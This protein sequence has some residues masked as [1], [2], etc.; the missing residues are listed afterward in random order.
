MASGSLR[1]GLIQTPQTPSEEREW[2]SHQRHIEFGQS[3]LI[4]VLFGTSICLSLIY[5][6]FYS[7][8]SSFTCFVCNS[9]SL[10]P[11]SRHKQDG[12][13]TG[14]KLT[15]RSTKPSIANKVCKS[16]LCFECGRRLVQFGIEDEDGTTLRKEVTGYFDSSGPEMLF[17]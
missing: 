6:S 1:R 11:F 3:R 8:T 17:I 7:L 15:D 9:L 4:Y 14:K 12:T 13:S 10:S 16:V 5:S 2:K